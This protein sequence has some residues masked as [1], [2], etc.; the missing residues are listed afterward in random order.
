MPIP[1]E[2]FT[3]WTIGFSLSVQNFVYDFANNILHSFKLRKIKASCNSLFGRQYIS[4]QKINI[5]WTKIDW[6]NN[7][8]NIL[9]IGILDK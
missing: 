7:N 4:K 5:Y 2:Q 6:T 8:Q 1:T 3:N 9:N